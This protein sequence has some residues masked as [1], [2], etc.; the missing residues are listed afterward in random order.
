MTELK[1]LKDLIL[2]FDN[3]EEI[4]TMRAIQ[5]EAIKW[6]KQLEEYREFREYKKLS[7]SENNCMVNW[8]KHFFN[9]TDEEL[10]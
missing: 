6:I 4:A 2:T 1:T 10:K 5:L 9:I 7:T 3:I 8:I